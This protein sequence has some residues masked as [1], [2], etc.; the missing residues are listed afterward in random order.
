MYARVTKITGSPEKLEEGIS[1]I[2]DTV[3]PAARSF[4]GFKGGYWLMNREDGSGQAVTFWATME[5][6]E[7]SEQAVAKLRTGATEQLGSGFTSVESYE[8]V[9]QA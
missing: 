9:A 2:R 5:D 1:Y 7:A 6:L 3:I 8:V 4:D